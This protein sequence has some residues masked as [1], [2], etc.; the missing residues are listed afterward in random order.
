MSLTL[1]SR[2]V[3]DYD[4]I[5]P[6]F[7]PI[8]F[9]FNRQDMAIDSI[10]NGAGNKVLVKVGTDITSALAIGDFAYINSQGATF[11]YDGTGEVLDITFNSPNTEITLNI[12]YIEDTSADGYINYLQNW[13]L[14]MKVVDPDN[15]DIDL[16]GFSIKDDGKPDGTINIDTSIIVD[17]LIDNIFSSGIQTNERIKYLVK[18]RE[19][20]D[21]SATSFTDDTVPI[22]CIFATDE[23]LRNEFNHPATLP[24]FWNGYNWGIGF[25]FNNDSNPGDAINI[26][27][28]QL[29]IN[30]GDL[31]T[32]EILQ[33]F[34]V[35]S[36]GL[37]WVDSTNM[38]SSINADTY[39]LKFKANTTTTSGEFEPTEFSNEFKI[40]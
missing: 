19:V 22:I 3:S 21:N 2:P 31:S 35:G 24:K 39:Y 27:V 18:Y 40:T 10:T 1:V 20:Y 12:D 26:L 38:A 6:G 36:Y 8:E 25:Y 33:N 13:Y 17:K 29:D 9:E 34:A 28:D 4:N 37:L 5:K 16:L 11:E 15:T 14:E 7:K 32:D 23:I 30:K